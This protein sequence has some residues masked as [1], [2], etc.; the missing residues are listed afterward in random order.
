MSVTLDEGLEMYDKA[1]QRAL[2]RL[3]ESGLRLRNSPPRHKNE[4]FDGRVPVNLASLRPAE[5]GE[6]YGLM[7]EFTDYVEGQ[8]VLA[9]AEMLSADEKLKLTLAAVRRVKIGTAQDK[10]DLA[11]IDARYVEANARYIE[12]K[13]YFELITAIGEAARRDVK[14]VS[15]IIETKKLELE[16]GG[17]GGSINRIPNDERPGAD[18]FR[19]RE[20]KD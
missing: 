2:D 18:R 6:Y 4:Y 7:V 10:G 13:T 14:F 1:E 8:I 20:R 3:S 16:M 19:R 12:A 15:R 17:R 5:I 9:R 11:I